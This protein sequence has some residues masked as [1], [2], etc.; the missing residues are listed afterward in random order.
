[1]Q[2]CLGLLL[3][4]C[5][6]LA[7]AA[8][9]RSSGHRPI[10]QAL[11]VALGAD[12]G[13]AALVALVPARLDPAAAP[14]EGLALL[15]RH[16]D[17][18]LWIAWPAALA[19]LAL[20]VLACRRV[21]PVALAYAGGVAAL[22]LGYPVLRFEVLR[23]AYLLVELAALAVGIASAGAWWRRTWGR[24]AAAM[25]EVLTLLLMAGHLATVVAGP[26]RLTLF[27]EAWALAWV[28]YS[29]ILGTVVLLHLGALLWPTTSTRS[30]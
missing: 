15:A 9:W 19:A 5:V 10:A 6:A 16:L 14:L 23:Q 13:R 11:S 21:W 18:A 22:V 24:R 29:L 27:G 2:F 17:R 20:H 3:C 30:P 4:T 7:W 26:Y 28:S 25:P 8:A 1:M 12:L